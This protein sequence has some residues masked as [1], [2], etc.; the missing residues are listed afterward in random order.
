MKIDSRNLRHWLLLALQGFYTLLA[1][2][3]RPL[4]SKP[5]KPIVLLYGHQFSGNLKA[6]Y[7]EWERSFQDQLSIYFLSLDPRH[8]EDLRKSGK[9]VLRCDRLRDMLILTRANAM[10]TDHGL[11]LMAPLLRFTSITFIDVWHGIPFKGF[12]P[13][14]FRI[15][16]RY[17]EVW[18][19]SALL[20]KI[21]EQKFGFASERVIDIG[22]A[23]TDKLFRGDTP[24]NSYR[25]QASISAK[26]KLVLYAPTW[27]HD[28][29][30]H[31]LFPFGESQ[32]SFIASLSEVCSENSATLVIRS[33]LNAHISE[34][35]FENVLYCPMNAFPDTEG[36]LQETD[37][38]ICDW[39]SIAFDYL[40][41][42]RPAIFVDVK[43][44]YRNGFSLGPEYRFGEVARDMPALRQ[45]LNAILEDPADY[46]ARRGPAHAD[47]AAQVYGRHT[48][49]Q[50]ARRQLER[51]TE[52]IARDTQ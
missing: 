3:L 31:E 6:L 18:V 47:I 50:A 38:L 35:Q 20:K 14:D 5:E 42:N 8:A 33:H 15:Q 12:V 4:A 21:Y 34:K 28:N 9:T 46:D 37:V 1:I 13:E 52:M 45:Q 26:N 23:R 32:E 43:S 22:Y 39:S 2:A 44:P 41:L 30:G 51:L 27:Q 24:V 16:Q 17:R 40:A 48:D 11:H 7:E 49:G 19:S 10:I 29:Q 36:L 25:C